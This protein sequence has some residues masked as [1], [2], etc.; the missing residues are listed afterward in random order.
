MPKIELTAKVFEMQEWLINC[1]LEGASCLDS[2]VNFQGFV[3]KGRPRLPEGYETKVGERQRS[4]MFGQQS[5]LSRVVCPK[6]PDVWT[7]K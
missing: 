1:K 3:S 5:E 4:P 6:M 7:A 2:K